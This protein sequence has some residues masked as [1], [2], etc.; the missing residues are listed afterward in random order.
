MNIRKSQ[1]NKSYNKII[2]NICWFD[3]MIKGNKVFK[4]NKN[5][6]HIISASFSVFYFQHQS[7]AEFL[8]F[9]LCHHK[10]LQ[11]LCHT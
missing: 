10:T 8:P 6:V 4:R 7:I 5:I 2:E 3:G 11:V 9:L 1:I